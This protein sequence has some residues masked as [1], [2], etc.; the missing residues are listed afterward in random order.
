MPTTL[1]VP[2][3]TFTLPA[4]LARATRLSLYFAVVTILVGWGSARTVRASVREETFRAAHSLATLSDLTGDAAT[5]SV[6]GAVFHRAGTTSDDA[7][8]VVLDRYEAY[9]RAR[10]NALGRA[11]AKAKTNAAMNELFAGVTGDALR[12][13]VIR[14]GNERGGLVVCFAREPGEEGSDDAGELFDKLV[15]TGDLAA[16]GRFRYAFA[17][18]LASG[19]TRVTTLWTDGGISLPAMFPT[20]GDAAGSDSLLVPRPPASRRVITARAEGLPHAARVYSTPATRDAVRAFYDDAM[21]AKGLT[22]LDMHGGSGDGRAYMRADGMVVVVAVVREGDETFV[23]LIEAG[24]SDMP[25]TI[26]GESHE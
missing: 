14:D 11:L 21:L 22:T 3:Q 9:C 24:S 16:M 25:N 13:G 8:S 20:T 19:R 23:S 2:T 5:V 6:N 12:H 17:E 1:K 4:R 7:P 18:R 15:K 10:P 26:T